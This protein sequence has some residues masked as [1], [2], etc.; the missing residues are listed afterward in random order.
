MTP[1]DLSKPDPQQ[2]ELLLDNL[3]VQLEQLLAATKAHVRAEASERD[4]LELMNQGLQVAATAVFLAFA[5][6]AV[7]VERLVGSAP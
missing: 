1:F 2:L 7:G 3:A 4:A 6:H 5:C